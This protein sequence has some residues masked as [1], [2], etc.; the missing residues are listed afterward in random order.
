M[1]ISK[2]PEE[3]PISMDETEAADAGAD[4][5]H[6]SIKAFGTKQASGHASAFKR[7]LNIDPVGATRCRVFFSRISPPSL[8]YMENQINQWVD[9]ENVDIKHVSEIIGVMEGKL[10]QPNLIVTV[11]Y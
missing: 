7:K 5:E 4:A 3:E 1:D 11:W 9:A 2:R 10:P 8:A 6:S